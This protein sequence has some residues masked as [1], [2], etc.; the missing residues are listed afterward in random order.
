MLFNLDMA[1]GQVKGKRR[2][3]TCSITLNELTSGRI[4][5]VFALYIYIYIYI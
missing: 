4:L 2:I 1:T 3:Q 5:L